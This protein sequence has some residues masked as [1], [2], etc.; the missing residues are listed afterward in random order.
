[1]SHAGILNL[2]ANFPQIPTMFVT[3][4][5]SAIP[6]LN[7]LELLG[8][9]GV[10]TS[11]SGST[12][13]VSGITA[14]AGTTALLATIGVSS[15]NSHEFTVVDGFVSLAGSG[16]V[17]TITSVNLQVTTT[18]TTVDIEDLRFTTAYVVDTAIS[19]GNAGT[20]TS[21]T[22]ALAAIAAGPRV[23][24]IFV[25]PNITLVENFTIP[26]NVVVTGYPQT[27]RATANSIIQGTVT[28]A[29][30]SCIANLTIAPTRGQLCITYFSPMMI[31]LIPSYVKN[32]IMYPTIS[33]ISATVD[34][35]S[36][37]EN[38]YIFGTS[39]TPYFSLKGGTYN[40]NGGAMGFAVGSSSIQGILIDGN[41]TMNIINTSI[42]GVIT[43]SS[44]IVNL[45]SVTYINAILSG[46]SVLSTQSCISTTDTKLHNVS[47]NGNST[48]TFNSNYD[49]F[50]YLDSS[51]FS[52][53]HADVGL[54]IN[55]SNS[56]F[57]YLGS[58]YVID[59]NGNLTYNHLNCPI[60]NYSLDA[61]LTVVVNATLPISTSGPDNTTAIVG[62]ASFDSTDF[63]VDTTGFVSLV[64]PPGFLTSYTNVTFS[65]SPYSVLPTDYFLSVD[66]SGGSVILNFP[67]VPI[68]LQSW[69]VKDRTGDANVNNIIFTSVSGGP[70]FDNQVSAGI[71]DSYN[72]NELMVNPSLNYELY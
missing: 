13:T 5:G 7:T 40:W 65:M 26:E 14:T 51:N 63:N 52:S 53:I 17:D 11:G 48:C 68:A 32:V 4:S 8:A 72:S 41:A 56:T 10:A 43:M 28:L 27:G 29:P 19:T 31:S 45:R 42:G 69:I 20:Y 21:V 2:L 22:A 62:H 25:R 3:D 70:T 16:T 33:A 37:F 12:V 6:V 67:D 64:T 34:I 60:S 57:N 30:G 58:T 24:T 9:N 36:N 71:V 35:I 61:G 18:G 50:N 59:G 66:S 49:V 54:N 46:N 38:C 15:F 44:G 55:I 1:M 23:G 47:L 39:A